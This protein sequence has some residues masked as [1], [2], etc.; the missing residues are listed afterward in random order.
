MPSGP[1]PRE[2]IQIAV[3]ET[4]VFFLASPRSPHE[5]ARATWILWALPLP[6]T[7]PRR[8]HKFTPAIL[9][10]SSRLGSRFFRYIPRSP[11]RLSEDRAQ[12]QMSPVAMA[13]HRRCRL[14][15]CRLPIR[16]DSKAGT[17]SPQASP[18]RDYLDACTTCI[19]FRQLGDAQLSVSTR[20]SLALSVGGGKHRCRP[21]AHGTLVQPRSA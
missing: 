6:H 21:W 16:A 19:T 1:E 12:A 5:S 2:R 17:L 15:A 4:S 18:C 20:R 14:G 11:V 9:S 8:R 13:A 3:A 7:L 10:R